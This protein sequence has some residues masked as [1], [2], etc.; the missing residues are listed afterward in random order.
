MP[1]DTPDAPPADLDEKRREAEANGGGG[2]VEHEGGEPLDGEDP[3]EQAPPAIPPLIIDGD[4]QLTLTIGGEKPTKATV[5]LRGGKID[6]ASGDLDKGAIV[7]LVLKAQV[8]EVHI[9]D[10]RDG[11]TGEVTEVERRHILKP[12]SVERIK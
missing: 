1:V 11:Q 7:D 10:K 2:P 9:V 4:G 8:A 12:V 6:V 3:D 5:K